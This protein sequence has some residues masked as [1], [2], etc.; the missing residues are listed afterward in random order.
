MENANTLQMQWAEICTQLAQTLSDRFV[1]RWLS[2]VV[3][4]SIEDDHVNLLVPSPCIHE[5]IK[6]NYLEKIVSLWKEKN[7]NIHAVNL[8]LKADAMPQIPN[9][10]SLTITQPVTIT[11]TCANQVIDAT[12]QMP[13]YLDKS[14]TFDTFVVGKSNQF[15]Y[16]AAKKIAEEDT[17]SFNPLYIH[18]GVGLG[19]THLLHA[20]AWR[21][22]ERHPEKN[23]LY[24]SSEQFFQ[25]FLHDLS[26]KN[27]ENFRNFVRAAD[28]LLIDD[29]QFIL[30]K[31]H[32]QEEFFHTF[33]AFIAE[34]KMVIL[35]A[36]SMP[37]KLQGIN[38]MLRTR[39]S[40]GLVVDIAPTDENLRLGILQGKN[41]E[42][43]AT[44]PN[45]V[46]AFLAKSITSNVRELEGALKRIVAHAELIG[47]P[48]NMDTT[49]QVL[50]DILHTYERPVKA[51]EI[52]QV[53][54]DYYKISL[55][56]L[57]STRR[58]RAFARPRQIAMYLT[59][60]LTPLSLPDIALCFKRDHT[61]IIHAVRTI[62]GLI[63][64]DK[65]MAGQIAEITTTLK[66]G[67]YA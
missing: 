51:P 55:D 17:V 30:G 46:L 28:V 39:I 37:A 9:N 52:Q 29:I 66:A 11:S 50:K 26:M 47:N 8:T 31:P 56:D 19:K 13:C 6:Q 38:D 36:N 21:I 63:Q 43:N 32:T 60:T 7:T 64:Q 15:A 2:K 48:I 1:M 16:A 42:M 20:I 34:K 58:D 57:Q 65:K 22:K 4:G 44:V 40:Q 24:L 35:S 3:P 54:A 45:D 23:V 18:A 67:N 27:T 61:T 33:N 41:K 14:H 59:K 49:Q 53:V 25:R 12:E 10:N 5:L 62:E